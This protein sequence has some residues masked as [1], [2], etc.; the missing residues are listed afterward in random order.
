MRAELPRS[1]DF[2]EH[3][4]RLEKIYSRVLEEAAFATLDEQHTSE[5]QVFEELAVQ[6]EDRSRD[7][8]GLADAAAAE[9]KS[10]RK[11][12]AE[13]FSKLEDRESRLAE[14]DKHIR[15]HTGL[16]TGLEAELEAHRQE[17]AHLREAYQSV[18]G[19]LRISM[20]KNET[21]DAWV[22]EKNKELAQKAQE[23]T[24]RD[25]RLA[26]LKHS[27]AEKQRTLEEQQQRSRAEQQRSRAE[28]QRSL[29]E[30]QRSLAEQ[31]TL[32]QELRR[33]VANLERLAWKR[34]R[35]NRLALPLVIPAKI[36]LRAWDWLSGGKQK[37]TGAD[38]DR[39]G[40]PNDKANAP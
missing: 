36:V 39:S 16:E 3:W 29:A 18:E 10:L 22:Q 26:E 34:G 38:E 20:G 24:D 12:V 31:Q 4:Q 15:H 5:A 35:E 17:V 2:D 32:L 27:L 1:L 25:G 8:D 40:V 33:H 11:D 23:I 28:Q 7:L 6:L 9:V 30:Q 21:F 13:L 37:G 19:Q 14:Q